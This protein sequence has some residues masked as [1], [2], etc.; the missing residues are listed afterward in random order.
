MDAGMPPEAGM[1]SYSRP[2]TL[3]KRVLGREYETSGRDGGSETHQPDGARGNPKAILMT[4]QFK[5]WM[6]GWVCHC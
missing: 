6:H 3:V 1:L 4:S 2:S 5:L